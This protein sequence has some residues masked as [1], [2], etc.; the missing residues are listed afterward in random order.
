MVVFQTCLF[1]VMHLRCFFYSC[2]LFH[3]L[4]RVPLFYVVFDRVP[5]FYVA[6]SI[7]FLLCLLLSQRFLTKGVLPLL[8]RMVLKSRFWCR[9]HFHYWLISCAFRFS[10]V[11]ISFLSSCTVLRLPSSVLMGTSH[12]TPLSTFCCTMFRWPDRARGCS[13]VH[14]PK[15]STPAVSISAAASVVY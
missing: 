4:H 3:I 12:D 9:L 14:V 10:V 8:P 11:S 2:L 5:L 15:L 6:F 13:D 1:C 7:F